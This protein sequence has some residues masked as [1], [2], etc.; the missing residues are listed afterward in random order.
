MATQLYLQ[1]YIDYRQLLATA[2]RTN[3][4]TVFNGAM[5]FF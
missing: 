2:L 5:N 4:E 3:L 1:P